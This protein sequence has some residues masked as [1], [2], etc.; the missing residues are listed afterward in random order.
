MCPGF[1]GRDPFTGKDYLIKRP[2]GASLEGNWR[3]WDEVLAAK[4]CKH[5]GVLVPDIFAVEDQR[6][7]VYLASAILPGTSNCTKEAF[8]RLPFS[9]KEPVFCS[10]MMHAW[11][12]NRDLVNVLGENFVMDRDKRVFYVDLGGTLCI[13]FRSQGFQKED[14]INLAADRISLFLL[15]SDNS[16][17]GW[18]YRQSGGRE[19]AHNIQQIQDFFGEEYFVNQREYHAR[20]A[21]IVQQ[22]SDQDIEDIVNSTGHTSQAKASRILMLKQRRDALISEIQKKYHDPDL[23][24][25]EKIAQVL[26][27]ILH[28]CGDFKLPVQPMNGSDAVV[29][30]TAQFL[31]AL[32][33]KVN[34]LPDNQICIEGNDIERLFTI[35][36]FDGQVVSCK[37]NRIVLFTRDRVCNAIYS[38]FITNSL[39]ACF[40]S[41]GHVRANHATYHHGAFKGSGEQGFEP[42]LSIEH[43][44]TVVTLPRDADAANICQRLKRIFSLRDRMVTVA[45]NGQQLCVHTSLAEL[46]WHMMTDL[47]VRK[48]VMVF[49]NQ[50]G[51]I[52][53]GKL[54][55]KKKAVTGF[56]TAGGNA[57]YLYDAERSVWEQGFQ[58]LGHRIHDQASLTPIG[59]TLVNQQANIFLVPAGALAL[60]PTEHIDYEAFQKESIRYHHFHQLASEGLLSNSRFD[61]SSVDLYLRYYQEKIQIILNENLGEHANVLVHI[62]KKPQSLGHIILKPSL[63]APGRGCISANQRCT[64]LMTQLFPGQYHLENR[65]TH[66]RAYS[67]I[68]QCIVLDRKVNPRNFY[69]KLIELQNHPAMR[70]GRMNSKGCQEHDVEL[71][72]SFAWFPSYRTIFLMSV[73]VI[74]LTLL[75]LSLIAPNVVLPLIAT[76]LPTC[77]LA[78]FQYGLVASGLA[79][80]GVFGASKLQQCL[81]DVSSQATVANRS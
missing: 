7:F 18:M 13:G 23:L 36:G 61:R 51:Q 1:I 63:A 49:E 2:L 52:S 40:Y 72:S 38:K 46:A 78:T 44:T 69:I 62:S 53:V 68:R 29:S 55:Q 57:E 64:A 45:D 66:Q 17:Y 32:K 16:E 65:V 60:A 50:E 73:W 71:D 41:F 11:L 31:N 59:S 75:I 37:K 58:E 39:Q 26:Q 21:I 79:A 34:F 10:L 70:D 33:P 8:H 19:F 67:R 54:D 42:V 74:S 22:F 6:G 4:L 35:L 77:P 76:V 80:L 14:T 30:D 47:G 43:G 56:A 3:V 27:R 20:G 81:W 15:A 5:A 28:R 24:E 9:S 12:G 25:A 48:T